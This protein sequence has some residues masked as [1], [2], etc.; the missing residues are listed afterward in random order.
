MPQHKKEFDRNV[1]EII[2][3]GCIECKNRTNHEILRT[4]SQTGSEPLDPT[5]DIGW[6]QEHQILQC[7]GCDAVSFRKIYED[8]E[9]VDQQ[10]EPYTHVELF[11]D[12]SEGRAPMEDWHLLPHELN[13]VYKETISALNNK[14]PIL[15]GIGIRAIIE[16]VTKDK[17]AQGRNLEVR[18]DALVTQGVLTQDGADILH[19][20]R[21]LGNAA[22]H[23][24]KAHKPKELALALDVV[25]H[26]LTAVYVLPDHATRT[27][28]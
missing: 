26:L 5:Y 18:I 4:V 1:G 15:A 8:S 21:V 20:L 27:F 16:T 12:R 28:T 23:E 3:L 7:K 22:A 14:Q 10:G 24:V 19:K 25:D 9:Q 2:R 13:R 6:Y 11:P 17:S